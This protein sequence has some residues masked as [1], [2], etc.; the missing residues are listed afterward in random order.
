M[1]LNEIHFAGG[2]VGTERHGVGM[3]TIGGSRP[4]QHDVHTGLFK[5]GRRHGYAVVEVWEDD[6]STVYSG[7]YWN[8]Q[9]H[10]EGVLQSSSGDVYDGQWLF[11]SQW[12]RG[13]YTTD[14]WLYTGEW[15]AGEPHGVGVEVDLVNGVKHEVACRVES[16]C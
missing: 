3:L 15:R 11:G 12:G 7:E 9:Q 8:D 4:G 6:E 2:L 5:R 14:K 10:G 13:R 16:A 1:P